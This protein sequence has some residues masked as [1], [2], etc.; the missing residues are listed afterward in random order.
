MEGNAHPPY[1]YS[2]SLI[3]ELLTYATFETVFYIPE[4]P[5]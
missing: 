5:P 3:L 1:F 2:K 4:H